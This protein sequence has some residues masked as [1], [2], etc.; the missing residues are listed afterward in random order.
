[1]WVATTAAIVISTPSCAAY[2]LI[3][4]T[5]TSPMRMSLNVGGVDH[6]PLKVRVI[7]DRIQEL[8]PYPSIPPATKATMGVLPVSVIRR[9]VS[10]Q[11]P[12]TQIPRH[13]IQEQPGCSWPADLSCLRRLAKGVL[14]IPKPGP[15]YRDAD[16]TA[17]G[18]LHR[19]FLRGRHRHQ[20]M[21]TNG[22]LVTRSLPVSQRGARPRWVG[23]MASN[24]T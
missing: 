14:R 24:S 13:R 2:S 10:P 6:Q 21:L 5:G 15:K 7:D 22:F 1:M 9:Q 17:P 11:S 16:A 4:P 18:Q 8:L 19:P 3:A 20:G 12:S 23:F